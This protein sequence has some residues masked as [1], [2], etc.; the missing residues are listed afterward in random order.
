[1]NLAFLSLSL[2]LLVVASS[3]VIWPLWRA[4]PAQDHDRA[5]ASPKRWPAIWLVTLLTLGTAGL[6][7]MVGEPAALTASPLPAV[8]RTEGAPAS[9]VA[10]GGVGPAQIAAMVQRLEQR[11]QTQPND[12]KGWRMLIKSYETMGHF[13]DAVLAYKRLLA[14]APPDPD[15]LTDYAVTLGMSKGQ[16]LAGEPEAL[17]EQALKLD[18]KHVQALALSGSA[19]FEQRD[20]KR[21]V[22]QW[23]K[24]LALVPPD[25]QVRPSIEANVEKARALIR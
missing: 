13:D 1:M 17:L 12:P 5:L 6:Y 18:P 16:T 11:L 7:L 15:V 20:Y 8:S 4:Q 24:L 23:Q 9:P 3:F 25:A 10:Q 21:A 22:A 14:I 2:A 19:A